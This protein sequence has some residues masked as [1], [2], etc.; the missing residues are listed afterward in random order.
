MRP[1]KKQLKPAN[2][3]VQYKDKSARLRPRNH[4]KD[5]KMRQYAATITVLYQKYT[6]CGVIY[7]GTKV[8]KSAANYIKSKV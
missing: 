1:L 6:I 3:Q 8:R 2:A 4:I 5:K 7:V